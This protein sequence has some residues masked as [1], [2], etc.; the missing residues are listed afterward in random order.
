MVFFC[1]NKNDYCAHHHDCGKCDVWVLGKG[2]KF[3]PSNGDRI[4]AM[5]DDE[6]A[7]FLVYHNPYGTE[8]NCLQ[9]LKQ[10][11]EEEV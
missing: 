7:E 9:W 6:L 11:A 2:G 4:R 10:P 5:S 1:F 3:V 8:K